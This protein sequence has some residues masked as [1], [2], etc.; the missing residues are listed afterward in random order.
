MK[1]LYQDPYQDAQRAYTNHNLIKTEKIIFNLKFGTHEIEIWKYATKWY[2][3]LE[4]ESLFLLISPTNDISNISPCNWYLPL[5]SNIF[6]P[7]LSSLCNWYLTSKASHYLGLGYF[8]NL[9]RQGN[10]SPSPEGQ[11]KGTPGLVVYFI[12]IRERCGHGYEIED[13]V[14][15]LTTTSGLR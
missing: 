1:Y 12:L 14:V 15:S 13:V 4:C 8:M 5:I 7:L 3:L 6:F 2:P 11:L 9:T 10:D